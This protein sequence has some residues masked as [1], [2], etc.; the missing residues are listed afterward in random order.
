MSAAAREIRRIAE[1]RPICGGTLT[2]LRINT[3]FILLFL[4]DDCYAQKE[5][6][7][8]LRK[9]WVNEHFMVLLRGI[10]C[11]PSKYW[12]FEPKGDRTERDQH[13]PPE[14][15]S[16]EGI[17]SFVYQLQPLLGRE[18]QLMRKTKG[19][20]VDQNDFR[21]QRIARAEFAR[22]GIDISRSDLYVMHGVLYMRGEVKPMPNAT[23]NDMAAEMGLVTKIL[24]QRPEIRDLVL[25][26]KVAGVSTEP[27]EAAA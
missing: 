2:P 1:S 25:E 9:C 19:V 17:T 24:R 20:M 6:T 14:A 13:A 12:L 26:V 4:F 22:R 10:P 15:P 5:A 23:F 7:I 3:R 11:S 16:A 18:S 27:I 8:N 21:G